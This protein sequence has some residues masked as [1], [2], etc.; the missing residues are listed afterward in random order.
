[1]QY[2]LQL[3]RD[4]DVEIV[5]K[6]LTTVTKNTKLPL[7]LFGQGRPNYGQELQNNFFYLL[8]NF[9]GEEAPINPA[10][11]MLWYDSALKYLK[12]YTGDD[13][14]KGPWV[15]VDLASTATSTLP[16]PALAAAKQI[17][18]TTGGLSEA[19]DNTGKVDGTIVATIAGASFKSSLVYGTDF[20][21]SNIP[22]GLV[23]NT[24]TTTTTVT[25]SF[26]GAAPNYTQ[27]TADITIA[28]NISAF[29]G[30]SGNISDLIGNY[31]H[32]A[33][34]TFIPPSTIVPKIINSFEKLSYITLKDISNNV[35][36]IFIDVQNYG[37]YIIYDS[38]KTITSTGSLIDINN[39]L[40]TYKCTTIAN[41]LV[42]ST[43]NT[44][45][46]QIM[47][48][49]P[50]NVGTVAYKLVK[51]AINTNGTLYATIDT[52]LSDITIDVNTKKIDDTGYIVDT[53]PNGNNAQ[54]VK[55]YN[56][57]SKQITTHPST[58]LLSVDTTV[59]DTPS[60]GYNL[61]KQNILSKNADYVV[62]FAG[63]DASG[64]TIN[65]NMSNKGSHKRN[66]SSILKY[67]TN[68]KLPKQHVAFTQVDFIL[69]C[70]LLDSNGQALY[71]TL[72]TGNRNNAPA[73]V[74]EERVP[75]YQLYT[76]VIV[77]VLYN[78][79]NSTN[80]A[81]VYTVV[82]MN[83]NKKI[84]YGYMVNTI[85]VKNTI[86]TVSDITIPSNI[87]ESLY[88]NNSLTYQ[89]TATSKILY[90]VFVNAVTG[91]VGLFYQG[92]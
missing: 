13:Y 46:S 7:T 63:T 30:L 83:N 1:M 90:K 56:S 57:T 78:G 25:I 9:C 86:S 47:E 33:T 64:M 84:P 75:T 32:V 79:Q 10:I 55:I 77:D 31:S 34:I 27:N 22:T 59:L 21:I 29:D 88:A 45:F 38:T 18:W 72:L 16:P 44:N 3:D 73:N 87:G 4:A 68:A 2:N 89:T 40:G 41:D 37:S 52:S 74:T 12:L 48:L 19:S 62:T 23:P 5:V 35:Y 81:D 6:Q 26:T 14:P 15:K 80:T 71:K 42:V 61:N 11:G 36:D 65:Y 91:T 49:P 20:T 39:T 76:T 53:I 66:K 85:E 82:T 70:Q 24:V 67:R 50:R 58:A 54:Q 43:D 92:E 69:Y 17:T 60:N 8:E 28:F 51:Y